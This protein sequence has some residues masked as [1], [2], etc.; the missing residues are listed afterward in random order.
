VNYTIVVRRSDSGRYIANCP[1]IPECYFNLASIAPI[2]YDKLKPPHPG[3]AQLLQGWRTDSLGTAAQE[4][5]KKPLGISSW[6]YA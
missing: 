3:Q 6:C 1:G 2:C 4:S 5:G